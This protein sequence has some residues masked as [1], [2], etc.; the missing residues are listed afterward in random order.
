MPRMSE[1]SQLTVDVL[2]LKKQLTA[3]ADEKNRIYAAIS[4][5]SVDKSLEAG[6]RLNILEIKK[7][8]IE[9]RLRM[10]TDWHYRTNRVSNDS[11]EVRTNSRILA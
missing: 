6:A 5:M 10:L 1:F 4:H 7:L 9:N 2:T 8:S 3:I 11:Y